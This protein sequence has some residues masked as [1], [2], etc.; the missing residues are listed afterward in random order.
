MSIGGGGWL[1]NW[2]HK[3]FSPK[4]HKIHDKKWHF[5]IRFL[6]GLTYYSANN[7]QS[8]YMEHSRVMYHTWI[9][10]KSFTWCRAQHVDGVKK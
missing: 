4:T 7:F 9:N 6:G 3:S 2:H 1:L 5:A 8:E 10:P